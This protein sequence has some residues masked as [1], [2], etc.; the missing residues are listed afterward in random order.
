[1]N[2]PA[3]QDA[4]ATRFAIDIVSDTDR[5]LVQLMFHEKVGLANTFKH[6]LGIEQHWHTGNKVILTCDEATAA[7][8]KSAFAELSASFGKDPQINKQTI[9][10]I[11]AKFNPAP[12][13]LT[14]DFQAANQNAPSK[15]RGPG[16][17]G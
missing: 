14:G 8:A 3:S 15:K 9:K 10:A 12:A 2:G 17:G 4:P 11:N 13:G 6:T 16:A 1:M 7:N 5:R